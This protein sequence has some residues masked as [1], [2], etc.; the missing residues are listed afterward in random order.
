MLQCKIFGSY[1]SVKELRD[2][3]AETVEEMNKVLESQVAANG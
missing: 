3:M 1:R 2:S